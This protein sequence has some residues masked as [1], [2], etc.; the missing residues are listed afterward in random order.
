MTGQY[1]RHKR[2]LVMEWKWLLTAMGEGQAS[3]APCS[4]MA[5]AQGRNGG[6]RDGRRCE[7]EASVEAP[8]VSGDAQQSG[9]SEPE[10]A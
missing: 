5:R 2:R 10:W 1:A 6:V 9:A 3:G 7:Q 4:S 8:K